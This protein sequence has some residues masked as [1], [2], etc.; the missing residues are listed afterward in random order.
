MDID[1]DKLFTDNKTISESSLKL[2]KKNLIKLNDNKPIK[3]FNFL[4]K[5]ED[6]DNKIEKYKPNTRRS[7]IIA[8]VSILKCACVNNKK[9]NKLYDLYFNKLMQLNKDLKDQTAM[10]PSENKNWISQEELKNKFDE[11]YNKVINIIGN[12]KKINED[13]YNLLLSLVI[14]GLYYLNEPR[15]NMDYQKMKVIKAYN[16]N[17]ENEY[18]YIDLKNKKFIFNN[19]KTKGTY[20]QQITEIN[21]DL[22]NIIKLFLKYNKNEDG[23]LLSNYN[24]K[25]FTNINDI[26]RILN[27]IFN[28]KIGCSM[29]RK[30]HLT[31]KY[32]KLENELAES[33]KAM[34]TSINTIQTNYIKK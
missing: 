20:N 13:E 34:G 26:T 33:A 25:N 21:D 3:N 10:T 31:N 30:M 29:L 9:L 5:V 7:Y 15:R 1:L 18:N 16:S 19:Y 24:N 4:N 8:I 32:G 12:K 28:K 23:Y 27:K 2:Y 11:L 22:F 17:L 14:F 6:I